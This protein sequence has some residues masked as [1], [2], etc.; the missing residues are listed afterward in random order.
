MKKS[1]YLLC[2]MF[3]LSSAFTG[4][5]KSNTDTPVVSGDKFDSI[6]AIESFTWSTTSKVN[7][8]FNGKS[9]LDY[10]LVLK[11]MDND[12]TVLLQKWQKA[13]EDYK[14]TIDVPAYYEKV[15][16]SY[17]GQIDSLDCRAGSASLT[18]D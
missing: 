15:L 13:N 18:I 12:G 17:G 16:V 10:G 9:P 7:F 3:A 6:S 2:S 8:Q 1:L 5:K 14:V 11:I 4:C